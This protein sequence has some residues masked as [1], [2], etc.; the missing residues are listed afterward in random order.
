MQTKGIKNIVKIEKVDTLCK[1]FTNWNSDGI[2]RYL[3]YNIEC[4]KLWKT[5]QKH[6]KYDNKGMH[7]EYKYYQIAKNIKVTIESIGSM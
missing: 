3:L 2:L 6:T 5:W 1:V 4:E 7:N